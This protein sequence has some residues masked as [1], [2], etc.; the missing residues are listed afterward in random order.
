[1]IRDNVT[2][3]LCRIQQYIVLYKI[4]FS[5]CRSTTLQIKWVATRWPFICQS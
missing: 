1:M 3:H 2:A 4:L 5:T